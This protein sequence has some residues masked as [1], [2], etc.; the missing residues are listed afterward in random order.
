LTVY[1]NEVAVAKIAIAPV[2]DQIHIATTCDA[3]LT[4]PVP[5]ARCLPVIAHEDGSPVT[6]DH[7]AHPGELLVLY[8]FGLGGVP[9][10]VSAGDASPPAADPLLPS[11]SLSLESALRNWPSERRIVKPEFVG[12]TP[13]FAGLYQ[14]NFFLPRPPFAMP[15]FNSPTGPVSLTVGG[16]TSADTAI[17]DVAQ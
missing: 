14:I 3:N 4:T 10:G 8:A 17:F 1:E 6:A 16:Q 12:L 2:P 13:G 5:G 11:L 7:P 15:T 9:P